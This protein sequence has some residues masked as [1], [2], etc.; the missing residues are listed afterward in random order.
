MAFVTTISMTESDRLFIKDNNI[1]IS[2]FLR[3]K[4]K[5]TRSSWG[6][7]RASNIH[8]GGS[9]S[10]TSMKLIT[11]SLG[12]GITNMSWLVTK[13]TSK[14]SPVQTTQ[15]RLWK[16][17]DYLKRNKRATRY[18]LQKQF[19]WGCGIMERLHRIL[20]N[21]YDYEISWNSKKQEY[22]WIADIKQEVLV[23][24]RKQS[25]LKAIT[26]QKKCTMTIML[27]NVWLMIMTKKA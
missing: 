27:V 26:V 25:T 10:W 22:I 17:R 5:E 12:R 7:E 14:S 23:W 19:G 3:Q 9:T 16:I 2:K 15:E 18:H 6:G 8:E 20:I 21:E 1:C 4:L 13:R 24:R 11:L